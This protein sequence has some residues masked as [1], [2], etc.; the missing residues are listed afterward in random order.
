MKINLPEKVSFTPDEPWFSALGTLTSPHE[1]LKSGEKREKGFG[2]PDLKRSLPGRFRKLTPAFKAFEYVREGH[3]VHHNGPAYLQEIQKL[4][5]GFE[6]D[7][8]STRQELSNVLVELRERN[9]AWLESEKELRRTKAL[10]EQY[11]FLSNHDLQEP[12][13]KL[14]IFADLLSGPQA[15]LNDYARR[16]AEK[17]NSAAARMSLLLKDLLNFSSARKIDVED[18]VAVDL[19]ALVKEAAED[20]EATTKKKNA[21]VHCSPLP[22]IQ[23]DRTQIKQVFKTLSAMLSNSTGV[24]S[25]LRY[26]LR[27]QLPTHSR[28]TRS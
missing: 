18:I 27:K 25:S 17:I 12:L 20:L 2:G 6:E 16:Y 9:E 28:T 14:Q 3:H 11:N 22:I 8:L 5:E 23:G 21:T 19:N 15:H 7:L 24:T 13:R 10:L 4:K 1:W 26:R